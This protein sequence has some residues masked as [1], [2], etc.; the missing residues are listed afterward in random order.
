MKDKEI[1]P[2]PDDNLAVV[3]F[4]LLCVAWP[5]QAWA[6]TDLWGRYIVVHLGAPPITWSAAMMVCFVFKVLKGATA[7]TEEEDARM[8]SLMTY[9][10]FGTAVF[11]TVAAYAI[12]RVFGYIAWT[13][14]F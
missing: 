12:A 2:K 9:E 6:A 8:R 11:F 14:Q 7:S 5:V 3:I 10:R 1:Y 4:L 13:I